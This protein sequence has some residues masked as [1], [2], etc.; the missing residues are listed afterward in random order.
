MNSVPSCDAGQSVANTSTVA[1]IVTP[2][3]ARSASSR[4]G[5]YT[6][7]VARFTGFAASGLIS[8]RTSR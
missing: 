6:A 7:I 3:G 4:N 5:R 2:Q 8:P 1:A